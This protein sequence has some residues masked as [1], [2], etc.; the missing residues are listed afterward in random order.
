PAEPL[1]QLVRQR[2][3]GGGNVGGSQ[4]REQ[5]DER[6]TADRRALRGLNH[7]TRNHEKA[8]FYALPEVRLPDGMS[9]ERCGHPADAANPGKH[10]ER[11][12]RSRRR[13]LATAAFQPALLRP[14]RRNG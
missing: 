1:A 9:K 5:T 11:R 8:A 14:I 10:W 13:T 4:A 3:A 6:R 7:T 12:I 2:L